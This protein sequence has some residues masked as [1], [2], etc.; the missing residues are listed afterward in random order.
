M[1]RMNFT[2][3]M[4]IQVHKYTH[5]EECV[6]IYICTVDSRTTWSADPPRSEKLPVGYSDP[7]LSSALHQWIQPT[8]DYVLGNICLQVH[9]TVQAGVVQGPTIFGNISSIIHQLVPEEMNIIQ[10]LFHYL[11]K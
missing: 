9:H 3:C 1:L 2:E 10:L 5:T 4:Y 8:G 11:Q 7:S 6:C